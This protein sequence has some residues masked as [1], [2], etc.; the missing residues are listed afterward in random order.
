MEVIATPSISQIGDWEDPVVR[1]QQ[2]R[3]P[4]SGAIVVQVDCE[5]CGSD[6][7]ETL[8][9]DFASDASRDS[10]SHFETV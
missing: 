3:Q 9:A 7:D 10:E 1:V 5:V 2:Q 8:L 4:G 6:D